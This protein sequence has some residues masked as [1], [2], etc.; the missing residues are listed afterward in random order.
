[1]FAFGIFLTENPNTH[2]LAIVFD[3]LP[4]VCKPKPAVQKKSVIRFRNKF[5]MT[6][7]CPP[8]TK[9]YS[10]ATRLQIIFYKPKS[11]FF[12]FVTG[13]FL[14]ENPI[15]HTLIIFFGF[16]AKVCKKKSVIR[17]RN[18]FGM[19]QFCSPTNF[20]SS[21]ARLRIVSFNKKPFL[22]VRYRN[23]PDGKS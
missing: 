17:F 6:L 22:C 3:F 12:V 14:T 16:Y 10:G 1:M 7:F 4:K 11:R 8:R 2:T 21:A 19:T 15:T 20:R 23:F 13:I 5:G 9:F 18:K